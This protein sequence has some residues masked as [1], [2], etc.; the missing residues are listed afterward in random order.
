MFRWH[1]F[2][3]IC[4]S[5]LKLADGTVITPV[6]VEQRIGAF[7]S[8]FVQ[9]LASGAKTQPV[10]ASPSGAT[11]SDDGQTV[12]IQNVE[13]ATLEFGDLLKIATE[14]QKRVKQHEQVNLELLEEAEIASQERIIAV[15]TPS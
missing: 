10:D 4:A 9:E 6:D 1:C 11:K 14:L 5:L 13:L 15:R 3:S 12:E 8:N 7:P 2:C